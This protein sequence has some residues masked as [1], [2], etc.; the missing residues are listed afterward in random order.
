MIKIFLNF[1]D[2][3]LCNRL[4]SIVE[5]S[6]KSYREEGKKVDLPKELHALDEDPIVCRDGS[7][8]D[9]MKKIKWH[10]KILLGLFFVAVPLIAFSTIAYLLALDF[11]YA[12]MLTFGVALFSSV[13]MENIVH[14]YTQLRY[15]TLAC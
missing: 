8:S 3:F 10:I 1:T 9:F 6:E 2:T 4:K 15:S 14:R 12:I 13:R 11:S 7:C 5:K